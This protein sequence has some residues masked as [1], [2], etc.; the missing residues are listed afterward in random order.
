[1]KYHVTNGESFFDLW[2]EEGM[3]RAQYSKKTGRSYETATPD[4][5]YVGFEWM[6]DEIGVQK[7]TV[8]KDVYE[9]IVAKGWTRIAGYNKL[10]K[11][12]KVKSEQ[13]IRNFI[14]RVRISQ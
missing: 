8:Y 7:P 9:Y 10:M 12:C 1:M 2:L 6:I 14:S 13:L 4:G 11:H 5:D 3:I